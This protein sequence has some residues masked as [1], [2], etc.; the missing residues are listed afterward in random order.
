LRDGGKYNLK[1]WRSKNK[2]AGEP[3]ILSF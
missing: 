3:A 1:K 2:K